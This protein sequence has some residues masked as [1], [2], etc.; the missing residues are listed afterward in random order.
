MAEALQKIK[1]FFHL[2]YNSPE[3]FRNR[4]PYSQEVATTI[5]NTNF[6]YL[7]VTPDGYSVIYSSLRNYSVSAFVLDSISKAFFMTAGKENPLTL[8]F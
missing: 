5:D 4:D 3:V 8:K 6:F 2:K 7:P 1:L